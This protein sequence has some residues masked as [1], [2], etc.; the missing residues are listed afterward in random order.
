LRIIVALPDQQNEFQL[1]Q[2]EDARATAARLGFELEI[3]DAKANPVHQVHEVLKAL[4]SEPRPTAVIVEPLATDVMESVAR[5][6]GSLGVAWVMMNSSLRT[7]DGLRREYP[8]VPITSLG[9]D[10]VE[11]GRV[12]GW[13]LRGLLPAGGNVLYIHG[14]QTSPAAR[15][16]FEGLSQ[17]V[18]TDIRLTIVDGQWSEESAEAAVRSWL[19]LRTWEKSP[20]HAVAAQDDAMARGARRAID[21][22]A[23]PQGLWK[24]IH[25]LGIDG[26]PVYGQKLV[27]Q[28][29]LSATVIMPSNTGPALELVD[30]WVKS[31]TLPPATVRLP[32]RPYP[33]AAAKS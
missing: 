22:I 3:L 13:Q 1:L 4:H 2:A 15:E 32:V 31:G 18:G 7:L 6:T 12:Q 5:K 14:P 29:R 8:A 19:R 28:G 26:L 10:Q 33:E 21:G 17:V 25:F 30:A 27:D 23:D 24:K 9:S 16:R 11:I 20:V